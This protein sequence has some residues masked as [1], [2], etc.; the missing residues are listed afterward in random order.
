MNDK[1]FVEEL[2]SCMKEIGNEK[3]FDF[4]DYIEDELKKEEK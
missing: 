2:F 4:A 3:A 1:Q